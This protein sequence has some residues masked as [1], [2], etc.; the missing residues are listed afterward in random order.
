[1]RSHPGSYRLTF[2]LP[3]GVT[4]DRGRH[5]PSAD[6][7]VLAVAAKSIIEI[8][9]PSREAVF[10]HASR[11]LRVACKGRLPESISAMLTTTARPS[12][13]DS[14]TIIVGADVAFSP[15]AIDP[16]FE[17]LGAKEHELARSNVPARRA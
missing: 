17:R 5:S 3:A 15:T 7:C 2:L 13:R 12:G 4:A 14:W 1:M 9:G 8:L 6:G 16:Y 11:L 10:D